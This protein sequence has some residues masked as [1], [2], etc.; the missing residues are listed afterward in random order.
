MKIIR[1]SLTTVLAGLTS[2]AFG[3]DQGPHESA[4]P[5]VAPVTVQPGH[6]ANTPAVPGPMPSDNQAPAVSPQAPASVPAKAPSHEDLSKKI[7]ALQK[8]LS[9]PTLSDDERSQVKRE[10]EN[11][12]VKQMSQPKKPTKGG[13]PAQPAI[14]R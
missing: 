10:L 12:Q 9:D 14:A 2:Y 5:G 7:D 6:P 13:S 4:T 8:K 1:L 3:S 11:V